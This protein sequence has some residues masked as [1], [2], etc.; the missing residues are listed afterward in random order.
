MWTPVISSNPSNGFLFGLG[1]VPHTY[2][3]IIPLL[4][5]EGGLLASLRFLSWWSSLLCHVNPSCFVLFGAQLFTSRSLLCYSL[6]LSSYVVA[7][8][9]PWLV[10]GSPTL[11][12]FV[13]SLSPVMLLCCPVSSVLKIVVLYILSF[14][15]CR[16]VVISG[17]IIDQFPF[18]PSWLEAEVL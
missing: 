2:I 16:H 13:S 17:G 8:D 11:A 9:T 6:I 18:I 1:K 3:A 5:T 12:S 4:T 10:V 15:C 7:W 14:C